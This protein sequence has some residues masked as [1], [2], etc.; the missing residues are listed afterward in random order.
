MA[1]WW[2]AF[3]TLSWARTAALAASTAFFAVSRALAAPLNALCTADIAFFN[4]LNS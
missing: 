4:W 2:A 1:A 3:Q